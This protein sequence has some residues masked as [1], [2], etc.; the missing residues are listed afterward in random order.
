MK[1]DTRKLAFHIS[2]VITFYRSVRMQLQVVRVKS[3]LGLKIHADEYTVHEWEALKVKF[4]EKSIQDR[5]QDVKQ[6][7]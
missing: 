1:V 7:R 5:R 2:S 6:P 4:A 3:F